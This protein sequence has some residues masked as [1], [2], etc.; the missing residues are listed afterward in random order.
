MTAGCGGLRDEVDALAED[1]CVGREFGEDVFSRK[2]RSASLEL[3]A[4][5]KDIAAWNAV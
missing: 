3:T 5:A 2:Y 4:A 1:G